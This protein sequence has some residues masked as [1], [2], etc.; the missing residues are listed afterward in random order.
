MKK[1]LGIGVLILTSLVFFTSVYAQAPQD[2]TTTWIGLQTLIDFD[3]FEERLRYDPR[4]EMPLIPRKTRIENGTYLTQKAFQGLDSTTDP[5]TLAPA[6]RVTLEEML[7]NKWKVTLNPSARTVENRVNSEC[8]KVYLYKAST[9]E[10]M[11][12]QGGAVESKPSY[13]AWNGTFADNN[14][15]MAAAADPA[16][17]PW[18]GQG[19]A[20]YEDWDF[21][22]QP[23]EE[24][25]GVN[26][27]RYEDSTIAIEMSNPADLQG[28]IPNDPNGQPYAD[29]RVGP[30]YPDPAA[31]MNWYVAHTNYRACLGIRVHFP[32]HWFNAWAKVTPPFEINAYQQPRLDQSGKQRFAHLR[33]GEVRN[34][35]NGVVDNVG[36]LK[37]IS[38]TVAGRNYNNSI[39]IRLKDQNDQVQEYFMGYLNFPGWR[40]LTWRNP[41]YIESVSHREI[42]RLPLYPREIPYRKFDSFIIYR[43]GDQ[44][45]GDFVCY[46]QKID[47]NYDLAIPSDFV[48][49]LED[50]PVWGILS[51]KSWKRAEREAVRNAEVID[52]RKSVEGTIS[53]FRDE[54]Y[55]PVNNNTL[56]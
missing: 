14:P 9:T 17:Y 11:S 5:L 31:M 8:K 6:Y 1:L 25:L 41:N 12:L 3:V 43:Q 38:I 22:P 49:Q 21:L 56:R 33:A 40:N 55:D 32:T 44:L 26:Y 29:P 51:E 34:V 53:Q 7:L 37:W 30:A 54:T 10:V 4:R 36:E 47:M 42:F 15:S 27:P 2:T 23:V 24:T 50:E 46:V 16:Q 35:Q 39:A 28:I 19:A 13:G 45:G 52:L 48:Q 18:L 20:P